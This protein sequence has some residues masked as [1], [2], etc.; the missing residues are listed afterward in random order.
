M[1]AN[2]NQNTKKLGG[3]LTKGIRF[4]TL[5]GLKNIRNKPTL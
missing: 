1:C 5:R 2:V 3:F 4:K